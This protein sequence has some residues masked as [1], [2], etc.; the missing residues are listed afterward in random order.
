MTNGTGEKRAPVRWA[1]WLPLALFVGFIVVVLFGLLRPAG[2]EV[3]SAM[4][5]KPLPAFDLPAAV[6]DRPGLS[7][8]TFA[9][10]ENG[11]KPRLLN[12]FASWCVPCAVEAPQLE[13]L[14]RAG[15]EIDGVAI[16]DK[17]KDVAAF[18]ARNGNPFARIGRDDVSA[19][20]MAIGSSGVPETFVIDAKGVIR[21]QHIGDIR[22]DQVPM[23]LEKLREA[24]E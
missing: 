22:P 19:V 24:E 16:R 2:N 21:Y 4:I 5:G 6:P 20:Q 14:R 10:G 17:P 18:L 3:E 1:L 7:S 8:K 12:V 23:I 13:A 9:T 15:V 11:G